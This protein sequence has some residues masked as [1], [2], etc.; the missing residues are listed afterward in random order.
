MSSI[1]PRTNRRNVDPWRASCKEDPQVYAQHST[2]PC[3]CTRLHVFS[4]AMSRCILIYSNTRH[5]SYTRAALDAVDASGKSAVHV[6]ASHNH[7][8]CLR[9]LLENKADVAAKDT[10]GETPLHQ[11]VMIPT[12]RETCYLSCRETCYLPRLASHLLFT[13]KYPKSTQNC[14]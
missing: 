1:R 7:M 3:E 12:C 11:A 4:S 5:S 9:L 6:S 2:A 8:E 10:Q 14:C 13:A